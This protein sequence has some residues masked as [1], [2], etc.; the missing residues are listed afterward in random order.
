MFVQG[1]KDRLMHLWGVWVW[2]GAAA[3][4]AYQGPIG[5]GSVAHCSLTGRTSL[6]SLTGVVSTR[7]LE[8]SVELR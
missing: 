7:W 5:T 4:A 1:F 8:G 6:N 3:P 2:R